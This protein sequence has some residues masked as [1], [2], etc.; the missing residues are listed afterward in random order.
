MSDRDINLIIGLIIA[1]LSAIASACATHRKG[2]SNKWGIF[3]FFLSPLFLVV[4]LLPNKNKK[5]YVPKIIPCPLCHKEISSE[6]RKCPSCGHSFPRKYSLFSITYEALV[7]V[8]W[9]SIILISIFSLFP[10]N[11]ISDYQYPLPKCNSQRAKDNIQQAFENSQFRRNFGLSI[12]S[13]NNMETVDYAS[14][15]IHC[16]AQVH[17]NNATEHP[18]NYKFYLKNNE[19]YTEMEFAD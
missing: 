2:L 14:D 19:A 8:M 7:C 6:V 5:T 13:I 18:I 1:A 17:L 12:I 16:K 15:G 9:I 3:T 11:F 10:N 4:E